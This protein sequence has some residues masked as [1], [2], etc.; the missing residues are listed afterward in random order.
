M[1]SETLWRLVSLL[2]LNHQTLVDGSTGKEQLRE[3]LS[4][5]A[6]DSSRDHE[7]IKGIKTLQA[8]SVTGQV[9]RTGW[10]GFCR[11]TEITLSFEEDAFVGGSPLLLA[12]VLARF[13]ALY[14]SVNSF[15]LLSVLRGDEVWKQW[16]PMSGRHVVL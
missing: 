1:G 14:T 15:V 3:M 9:G 7:Q 12:A 13:F 4:L 2:T 8:R 16:K 11:G 5:F 10:R 6:S